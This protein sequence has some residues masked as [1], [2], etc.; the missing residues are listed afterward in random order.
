M[1]LLLCLLQLYVDHG[2]LGGLVVK[3]LDCGFLSGYSPGIFSSGKDL[4]ISHIVIPGCIYTRI[5]TIGITSIW[6][7]LL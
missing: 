7:C 4:N 2:V 5:S 3:P 1:I 6:K